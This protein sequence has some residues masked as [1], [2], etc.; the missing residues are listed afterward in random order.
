[1]QTTAVFFPFDCFGSAGTGRGAEL[2][3]DGVREMLADNREERAPA[4]CHVYTPHIQVKE[5][6]FKNEKEQSKWRS[7][8]RALIRRVLDKSHRLIWIAGN[9]L[10]VLPLYDELAADPDEILVIQF[11][12]HLDI[13]NLTDC[14]S[15]PTHGNYLMHAAGRLPRI[16]NVGSRDL[17]LPEEHVKRYFE[18]VLSAEQISRDPNGSLAFLAKAARKAKRVIL[19]LDCD[20]FEP[21]FFPAVLHPTPFGLA[22]QFLLQAISEIGPARVEVIA[23][24]EFAPDRDRHDQSLGTLLWLLEWLFL[25]WYETEGA[26]GKS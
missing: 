7:E 14:E 9:H 8:G 3:A 20:V 23:L 4:R 12:A 16:I 10:G 6:S 22:P 13:F 18:S 15:A 25:R 1:M 17:M 2:L 26:S 11:D 24:S 21:A 5:T 19:D